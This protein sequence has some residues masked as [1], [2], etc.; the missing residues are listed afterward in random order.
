M[1]HKLMKEPLLMPHQRN[2]TGSQKKG[3]KKASGFP[4]A[5]T[6]TE[7]PEIITT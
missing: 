1:L 4:V 3:E 6:L 2:Y 5:G 7:Q